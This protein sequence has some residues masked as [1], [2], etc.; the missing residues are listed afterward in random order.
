MLAAFDPTLL[1]PPRSPRDEID[2]WIVQM[3]DWTELLAKGPIAGCC[4]T[5]AQDE[6]QAAWWSRYDELESMLA[7][8][9]LPYRM[10]DLMLM[11]SELQ[12]RLADSPLVENDEVVFSEVATFPQFAPTGFSEQVAD[13]FCELLAEIA[14]L[15]RDYQRVGLVATTAAAWESDP[16]EIHVA[17][18]IALLLRGSGDVIEPASEDA[19]VSEYLHGCTA[20]G[21]AHELLVRHPHRLVTYPELAVRLVW[22]L[23]GG[24]PEELRF[25][26]SDGFATSLQR[27][28]YENQGSSGRAMGCW[29]A[30]AY[31]AAGRAAELASLQA[32]HHHEGS[33]GGG[34]AVRNRDGRALYRGWLFQGPDA[35]RLFWWGGDT[36]EFLGVTGHDNPPP[37]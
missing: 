3:A 20:V 37:I 6:V 25:R 31:V 30:M 35:H 26:I 22:S 8:E 15:R 9:R 1:S 10:S 27:L 32:H 12:L 33:G 17:A 18:D 14:L 13:C 19:A 28:S 7:S 23:L 4:R 36:P 5:A 24:D 2:A 34:K 16:R 11:L 21:E 29:R